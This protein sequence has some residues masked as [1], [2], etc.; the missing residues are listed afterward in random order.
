[1]DV[2]EILAGL[3]RTDCHY[4]REA[5]SESL[6]RRDEITP[7][8]LN[9]LE[10]VLQDPTPY[11]EDNS[12]FDHIYAMYL[13]AQCRE[14]RAYPLL[15]K[16]FPAPGE[17]AFDLVGDTV[18]EGLGK[19]LA[20]VSGADI[21]GM[22]TLIENEHTNEYVRSAALTGLK[23]LVAC[24]EMNRDDFVQYL[25]KLFQT[26]PPTQEVMTWVAD[27]CLDIWPEE[28]KDELRRAFDE[29]LVDTK[30]FDWNDVQRALALELD[31]SMSRLRD[32][33]KLV[34]D[35]HK[36]MSWWYSFL[37]NR[38]PAARDIPIIGEEC[39]FSPT[40]QQNFDAPLFEPVF[41]T[42]PALKIGRIEPC[43]CGSG[44]KFKKCCGA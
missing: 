6:L 28:L 23:T 9:I 33:Y 12:R 17:F 3:L 13:L 11:I 35:V 36:D 4:A 43:S 5:V 32:R 18:T 2:Q 1:M 29:D 25:K 31:R 41:V 21:S 22:A 19:I 38:K 44:K 16:I 40:Q 14:A 26:L 10:S 37:E 15:V 30:V 8:L 39:F 34:T 7:A 27:A 42:A 24:G 20:S